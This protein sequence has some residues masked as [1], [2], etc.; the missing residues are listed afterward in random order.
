SCS[1]DK[2]HFTVAGSISNMPK[3][4]VYLEELSIS[5]NMV[6]IDSASSDDKGNFEMGGTLQEA[7]LYRL[8]FQ[9][10]QFIILSLEKGTTKVVADWSNLTD[11]NVAGSPSSASLHGFLSQI[12]TSLRDYNTLSLVMDSM[13][14]RGNDSL[15]AKAKNEM[16]EMNV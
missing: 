5:N 4:I 7:G 11:C 13:R 16:D 10:N 12:R 6:V 2:N 1:S 9:G 15:L 8:R 14:I 3:Q